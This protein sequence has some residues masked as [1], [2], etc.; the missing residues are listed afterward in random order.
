MQAF[1][2]HK[3]AACGVINAYEIVACIVMAAKVRNN[4]VLLKNDFIVD[5]S[6]IAAGSIDLYVTL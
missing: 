4:P 1:N 5:K 3:V 2:D 6:S